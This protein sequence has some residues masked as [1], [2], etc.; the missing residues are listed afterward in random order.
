MATPTPRQLSLFAA[1]FAV[2]VAAVVA[3]TA[4]LQRNAA[5]TRVGITAWQVGE[6]V[7]ATKC[8]VG[9]RWVKGRLLRRANLAAGDNGAVGGYCWVRLCGTPSL[10]RDQSRYDEDDLQPVG[11]Q[12]VIDW[13]SP[14]P[15]LSLWCAGDDQDPSPCACSPGAACNFL[16][17]DGGAAIAAPKTGNTLAEGRWS[18]AGCVR[19]PCV[20]MAGTASMPAACL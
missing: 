13:V 15:T 8:I 6:P 3:G 5:R 19:K 14:M 12:D 17:P 18:G 20:E 11:D 10:L 2:V 16:P 1:A 7:A 4:T 9:Q